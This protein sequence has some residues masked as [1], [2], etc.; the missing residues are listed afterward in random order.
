VCKRSHR[1]PGGK[2]LRAALVDAFVARS[3]SPLALDRAEALEDLREALSLQRAVLCL[4]T[5]EGRLRGRFGSGLGTDAQSRELPDSFV[6][7]LGHARNLFS[8]LCLHARDTLISDATEGLIAER[9]PDCFAA[10]VGAAT[11]LVLPL[12]VGPRVVGMIC[13]DR[14]ESRSIIL[15]PQNLHLLEDLRNQVLVAIRLRSAGG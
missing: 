7:P 10:R 15:G 2:Q 4:R 14:L 9:L 1:P 8:V 6:V 5:P 3:D 13:A 12:L 11:F